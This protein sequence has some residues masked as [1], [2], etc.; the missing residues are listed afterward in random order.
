MICIDCSF[1]FGNGGS[2]VLANCSFCGNK[3]NLS[4]SADPVCSGFCA[5]ACSILHALCWFR[6]HQQ[7]CPFIFSF[8]LHSCHSVLSFIFYIKLWQE[9]SSLSF[10][11][12]RLQWVPGHLFFPGSNMVD[13]VAQWKHNSCPVPLSSYFSYPLFIFSLTGVYCLI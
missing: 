8:P 3:A 1:P 4:F 12:T 9:L 11:T 10:F 7:V 13:D 2:G 5:E 6:H